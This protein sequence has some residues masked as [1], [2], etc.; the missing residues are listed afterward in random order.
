MWRWLGGVAAIL[1]AGVCAALWHAHT[2]PLAVFNRLSVEQQNLAVYDAFW[3]ALDANYYDPELLAT[4]RMRELRDRWR[5][6]ARSANALQ[7]HGG[8]LDR[9]SAQFPNSHVATTP[10][11]S[12]NDIMIAAL[13]ADLSE[14]WKQVRKKF[15]GGPGFED[16]ITRRPSGNEWIVGDVVTGSAAD[17][18]GITPGWK[19]LSAVTTQ[20]ANDSVIRFAGEFVPTPGAEPI[21]IAFVLDARAERAHFETRSLANGST[22][23]RFDAFDDVGKPDEVI[24]SIDRAGPDGLVIDVRGN[25]GGSDEDLKRIAG[26]LLGNDVSIG[27]IFGRGTTDDLRTNA[28]RHYTGPL[29][30]LVG[31]SSASAAEVLAAA[32]Q[33]HSRG[34]IIGRTTNGSVLASRHFPLPDGGHVQVPTHDFLRIDGRR[35]EGV[36]VEPDIDVMP[37]REDVRAGRDPA[38]ERTLDELSRLPTARSAATSSASRPTP[39]AGSTR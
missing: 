19:I 17:E 22:Y 29:V 23:V 5:T 10:R 39:A 21:K 34:K 37:T 16:A 24:A 38:L 1:A 36:G 13:P 28:A 4:P 15:A 26:R 14:Q 9:L 8:V 7:I 31:P 27:T 6:T 12:L 20:Q 11:F 25:I 30:V 35:I 2:R 32:V 33:D 18:A 3:A